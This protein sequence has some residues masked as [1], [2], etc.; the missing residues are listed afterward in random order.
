M[1]QTCKTPPLGGGVKR[2]SCGGWTREIPTS[3]NWQ[4]QWLSHRHGM[5]P[6]MA[7]AVAGLAFPVD[8]RS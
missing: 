7:T 4:A 5:A 8:L 6:A 2:D 3:I 1:T